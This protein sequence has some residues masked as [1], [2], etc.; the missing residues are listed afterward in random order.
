MILLR[1]MVKVK[2]GFDLGSFVFRAMS[3]SI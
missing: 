3:E 1:L 2:R